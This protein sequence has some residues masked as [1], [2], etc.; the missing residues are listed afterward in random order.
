M[1]I[2][3]KVKKFEYGEDKVL[4][5]SM[6]YKDHETYTTKR[7]NANCASCLKVHGWAIQA[8]MNKND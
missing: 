5:G 4:C 2:H 3:I 6:M 7:K 8:K 1:K